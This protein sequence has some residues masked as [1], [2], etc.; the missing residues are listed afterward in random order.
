M[1]SKTVRLIFST[2][3]ENAF[4][5]SELYGCLQKLKEM[6]REIL[7]NIIQ[8]GVYLKHTNWVGN[9]VIKISNMQEIQA[10]L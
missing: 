5:I 1:P 9:N 3:F 6:E 2:V 4:N 10:L 8:I 7:C